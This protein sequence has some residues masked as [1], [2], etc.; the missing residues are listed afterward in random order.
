VSHRWRPRVG[1]VLSHVVQYF[2]PL[3]DLLEQRGV[4]EPMVWYGNDAGH[5]PQ[6]DPGF[7]H[8]YAWDLDLTGG[9]PHQYMT[10]GARPGVRARAT[11]HLR[12]ASFIR[13]CDVVVVHGYA[14]ALNA[15]AVLACQLLSVPYLLRTDT[16]YR[17]DHPVLSPRHWWPKLVGARSAG[18]LAIGRR[19][20]EA[21]TRLGCPR[22]FSAPFAVDVSRYRT[23]ASEVRSRPVDARVS[24]GLPGNGPVVAFAGKFHD[25]KRPMD[26]I[27]AMRLLPTPAHLLMIGDGVQRSR[28]EAAAAGFPVT[29]TGFLNQSEMPAALACADVLVLPSSYEPWGLVVN[30]AMASGCVPVA[31]QAVGAAPDLVEGLGETFPAGDVDALALAIGRGLETARRPDTQQRLAERLAP[32]SVQ[33]CAEGY[34][35][36]VSAVLGRAETADLPPPGTRQ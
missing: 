21:Q 4:V 32:H 2:S 33:R 25:A 12:L 28:L 30:E 6:W 18:A 13:R 1:I 19:N 20:A 3:F 34:E 5:R 9:H 7:G 31:S 15:S 14:S 36:A 35:T 26:L 29:F 11:G 27:R 23:V 8:T 17:A 24:I 22:V 16:S 10:R